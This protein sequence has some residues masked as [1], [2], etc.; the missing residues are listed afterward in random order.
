MNV[1]EHR[2][3]NTQLLI[4][5]VAEQ[6]NGLTV[7]WSDGHESFFHHIWL[8][9]CCYCDICGDSYSSKRY[10]VPSDLCLNSAPQSV[11]ID[12]AGGLSVRWAP[13]GHQ[14]HYDAGWLRRNCYD[15]ASRDLRRHKPRLWDCKLS[16]SQA[17]VDYADALNTD[18]GRLTFYR[19]LRDF[20]FVIVRDGPREPGSVA[21]VANMIGEMG[22]SAYTQIFDLTPKS[23]TRT[24]G[25]STRHVPPHT[26]EAFRFS[27]PGVNILACVRPAK[28]GG[29]TVLTDGFNIASK[30]RALEPECFELLATRTHRFHRLHEGKL[31]QQANVRMIALDDRQEICGVRVHT[32][33]SGPMDLAADDVEPFYKA[34]HMLCQLMM[35]PENQI[36]LRLNAGDTALFDN[37][38]VL[39]ARTE[40]TD[41]ERLMQICNVS[42]EEFHERLRILARKMGHLDEAEQVLASGMAY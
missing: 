30:L 33:A 18:C 41:P 36:R 1:A 32:R 40:F 23:K 25:N 5:G 8:R 28:N 16:V 37:H 42:R 12:N 6:R 19:T 15:D 11:E 17:E 22:E 13:D 34:H 35:A 10:V 39:H 29:D 7:S 26:D 20:G 2:V 21:K 9:D 3:A 14:S 27:P 31:D 24:I 4:L 38:R